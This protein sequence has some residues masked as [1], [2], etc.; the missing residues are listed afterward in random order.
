MR[1]KLETLAI[2]LFSLFF[3]V[4]L[5]F[6]YLACGIKLGGENSS[7]TSTG[8]DTS[9]NGTNTKTSSQADIDTLKNSTI[10]F[11]ALTASLSTSGGTQVATAG[12]TNIPIGASFT[13]IFSSSMFAK[14]VQSS[15]VTIFCAGTKQKISV[16]AV[17]TDGTTFTLTPADSLP[18]SATCIT[19]ATVIL[20]NDASSTQNKVIKFTFTTGGLV[21]LSSISFSSDHGVTST[22]LASSG[23]SVPTTSQ[24]ILTFSKELK[25]SNVNTANVS[26]NC[27]VS[28]SGAI[29]NEI[30][31]IEKSTDGK[32]LT[33][34]PSSNLPSVSSC[35]LNIKTGLTDL[36]GNPLDQ[37][38]SYSFTT[39]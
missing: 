7:D 14:N 35:T 3:F 31:S 9:T 2:S 28:G 5:S 15:D 29:E 19:T 25:A 20:Q 11:N 23:S 39:T 21:S 37:A 6:G 34:T 4:F 26:V 24:F 12:T 1:S 32:T 38:S 22:T 33:V 10:D 27:T 17:G 16:V 13:L 36:D 18:S 8:T 30:I